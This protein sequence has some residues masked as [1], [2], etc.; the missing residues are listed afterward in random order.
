M[1]VGRTCWNPIFGN[2]WT[3]AV[4]ILIFVPSSSR[5]AVSPVSIAV[6]SVPL[7]RSGGRVAFPPF[8]GITIPSVLL[9]IPVIPSVAIIAIPS[10][11][12]SM[13][14][15]P[16]TVIPISLYVSTLIKVLPIV[17]V[18]SNRVSTRVGAILICSGIFQERDELGNE[19]LRFCRR[20]ITTSASQDFTSREM[21]ERRGDMK[22]IETSLT[23]S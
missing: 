18:R 1:G 5:V 8:G 15:P 10:V 22:W 17:P 7:P 4:G 3:F 21:R 2:S 20:S 14:F 6:F 12:I 19:A 11:T 16:F 13:V 9:T 23:L